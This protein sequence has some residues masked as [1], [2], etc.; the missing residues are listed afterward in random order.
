MIEMV[1][2]LNEIRQTNSPPF[3]VFKRGVCKNGRGRVG[4][5][6]GF[7]GG[8]TPMPFLVESIQPVISNKS[9]FIFEQKAELHG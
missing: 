2:N 8:M 6:F 5:N 7:L 3:L 9:F 1:F 4:G